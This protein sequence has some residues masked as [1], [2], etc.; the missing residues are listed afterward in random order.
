MVGKAEIGGWYKIKM[1][2]TY[3]KI[4]KYILDNTCCKLKNNYLCGENNI[5]P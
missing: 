5:Y 1:K 3:P 2:K 4:Y